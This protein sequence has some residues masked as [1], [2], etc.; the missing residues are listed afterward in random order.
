MKAAAVEQEVSITSSGGGLHAAPLSPAS[1][2]KESPVLDLSNARD[3][4][5]VETASWRQGQVT[6][7][8]GYKPLIVPDRFPTTSFF[9]VRTLFGEFNGRRQ[10]RPRNSKVPTSTDDSLKIANTDRSVSTPQVPTFTRKIRFAYFQ[11]I[12]TPD[13]TSF[14]VQIKLSHMCELEGD[15][16][17]SLWEPREPR[18]LKKLNKCQYDRP[19][20]LRFKGLR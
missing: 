18:C 19:C 17:S 3:R 4:I 2:R 10:Q 6:A 12:L 16:V 14:C 9:K 8:W 7:P 20:C 5:V 1:R 13:I 15:R 11:I